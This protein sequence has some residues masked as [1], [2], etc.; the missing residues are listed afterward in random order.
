MSA[1][2]REKPAVGALFDALFDDA[3]IFP[4]GEAPLP[5]AV[6]RHLAWKASVDARHIGPFVCA[7]T[8]WEELRDALPDKTVLDVAL[9]VPGGVEDLGRAIAAATEER[10]VRVVAVELPLAATSLR[11]ATTVSDM[12]PESMSGYVELSPHDVDDTA[13]AALATAGLRLKV[14]TGGLA[15][16][17]FP[18]ED[19]LADLVHLAVRHGLPFKATAGLHHGVRHRD[20]VTGFEHHG[21]LNVLLATAAAAAR[22]TAPQVRDVLAHQDVRAVGDAVRRLSPEV[23]AD[24]RRYFRS[25]GTCSIEEPLADLNDLRLLQEKAA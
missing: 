8:R 17:D 10:R 3:A 13:C 21:F 6:R 4:P 7:A 12:L 2:T 25:F 1:P 15:T 23:T 18:D 24:A 9:T 16:T 20:P 19:V 5:E 22:A 11:A 14:R